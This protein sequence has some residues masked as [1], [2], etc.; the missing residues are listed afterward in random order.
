[1]IVTLT[2]F[3]YYFSLQGNSGGLFSMECAFK[4]YPDRRETVSE[5][6][7]AMRA[8]VRRHTDILDSLYDDVIPGNREP[9]LMDTGYSMST[10]YRYRGKLTRKGIKRLP[11]R[12]APIFGVRAVDTRGELSTWTDHDV[13]IECSARK[14]GRGFDDVTVKTKY[15]M[16]HMLNVCFFHFSRELD[17]LEVSDDARRYMDRLDRTLN[18]DWE[19]QGRDH[20][21]LM[22]TGN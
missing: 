20:Y 15:H 22:V 6:K 10:G 8:L 7:E 19:R 5:V 11:D 3:Q 21:R 2:D 9:I 13:T 1:M 18:S 4:L 16:S 12:L 14:D 17:E